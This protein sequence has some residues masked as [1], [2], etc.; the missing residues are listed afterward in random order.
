MLKRGNLSFVLANKV[1]FRLGHG[2]RLACFNIPT[3]GSNWLLLCSHGQV[4]LVQKAFPL[5]ASFHP[6]DLLLHA[7]F[8]LL[9]LDSAYVPD[10]FFRAH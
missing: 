8:V 9:F 7:D 5:C 4:R 1:T 6:F 3:N 2:R 10:Y